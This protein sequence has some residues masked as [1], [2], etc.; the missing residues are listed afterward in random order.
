MTTNHMKM[1][2]C[3][4]QKIMHIKF[5]SDD[6]AM[7]MTTTGQRLG[8]HVPKVTLSA[9]GSTSIARQRLINT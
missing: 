6:I 9:T 3:R 1:E 2:V 7:H 4:L 5:T 8:K